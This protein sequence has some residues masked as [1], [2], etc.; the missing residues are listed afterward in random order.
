MDVAALLSPPQME[1]SESFGSSFTTQRGSMASCSSDASQIMAKPSGPPSQ[2]YNTPPFSPEKTFSPHKH[3]SMEPAASDDVRDPQLYPSTASTG[4]QEAP[5]FPTEAPHEAVAAAVD[6]HMSSVAWAHLV[7]KPTK[8]EYMLFGGVVIQ[9]NVYDLYNKDPRAWYR[10]E[11]NYDK[12]YAAAKRNSTSKR[13]GPHHEPK[14]LAPAAPAHRKEKVAI[15]RLPPRAQRPQRRTPKTRTLDS[16]D[17][18]VDGASQSHSHVAP[19]PSKPSSRQQKPDDVDWRTI[20]DYCPPLSSLSNL[21]KGK[22]LKT[23]WR[24]GPVFQISHEP[25]AAFMHEDEIRIATTL[26]LHCA[27]Y[28]CSKRRIFQ[29][30]LEKLRVGKEFRRTDAQQACRIDVNKASKLWQAFER[31]G[32][33]ESEWFEEYL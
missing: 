31:V 23:D 12:I 5:L 29:A 8:E 21:P 26:R 28:L 17:I 30:R 6:E 19:A 13:S 2:V 15:P 25:E 33:F 18:D 22:V 27:T 11:R 32:W 14:R 3:D 7:A 24:A 10:Q 4:S 16:M 9:S 1:R 20:P